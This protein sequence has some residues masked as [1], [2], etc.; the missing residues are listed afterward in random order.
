MA[1]ARRTL[2]DAKKK[3]FKFSPEQRER[4][5]QMTD[6]AVTRAAES[7]PDSHPLTDDELRRGV[8]ARAVRR[9]RER[10]GMTQREFAK[11]YHFNL[12]RLQDL[13][14]GRT[15]PDSA[16][17]GYLKLIEHD[18]KLVKRILDAA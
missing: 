6:A 13:E 8:A 10:A 4:L 7:D 15:E 2:E 11:Q 9:A 18:P 5:D 12:R 1:T 16:L 17:E 14:Q 3:P